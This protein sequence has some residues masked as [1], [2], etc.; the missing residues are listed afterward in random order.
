MANL[1]VLEKTVGKLGRESLGS[2]RSKPLL[3]KKYFSFFFLLLYNIALQ[4]LCVV[5]LGK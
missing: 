5:L 4:K 2:K 1:F 3:I